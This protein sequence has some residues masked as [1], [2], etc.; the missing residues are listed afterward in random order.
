MDDEGQLLPQPSG[1]FLCVDI[2]SSMDAS[3]VQRVFL[4]QHAFFITCIDGPE[5]ILL[6]ENGQITANEEVIYI[7]EQL[8]TLTIMDAEHLLSSRLWCHHL[9]LERVSCRNI[10]STRDLSVSALES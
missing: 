1:D 7:R 5:C 2:S 8:L 10:L 6:H 4:R 9:Q 3:Q